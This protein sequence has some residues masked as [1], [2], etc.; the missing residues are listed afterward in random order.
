MWGPRKISKT[1]ANQN[2]NFEFFAISVFL[3][4]QKVWFLHLKG[5]VSKKKDNKFIF[6]LYIPTRDKI[7][8]E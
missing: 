7:T 3:A 5:P 4:T 2:F 1:Q 6:F 8:K